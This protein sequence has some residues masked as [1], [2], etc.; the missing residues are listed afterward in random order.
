MSTQSKGIIMKTRLL[1]ALAALVLSACAISAAFALSVDQTRIFQARNYSNYQPWY[2][3]V[4][5]NFND[6]QIGSGVQFGQLAN[7]DFVKAI[8]C[9]VLTAFNA[10]STNTILFGTD[11]N[12]ANE[13]VASGI[14]AGTPGIYHLTTA[15]GLGLAATSAG[16]VNLI[17][18][19]VQTGTAATTGS[20]TC[21]FE[22]VT[23]NDM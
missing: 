17:G 16:A 18:K 21:V 1:R 14:T 2:Y 10:G 13:I 12:P 15:A 7:L 20:V 19:Y 23:N 22:V 6:A 5:I 8:D 11:K 4:T 9:Y 3:R